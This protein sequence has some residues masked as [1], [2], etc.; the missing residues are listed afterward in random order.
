[1]T[2]V[3]PGPSRVVAACLLL[4]ALV[5]PRSFTAAGAGAAAAAA[6]RQGTLGPA[7]PASPVKLIFVH[8]ST[9]EAWLNDGYGGLG[10]ALRNNNYFV[11]DTNYGWGPDVIGDSTDIPHWYRW[12][13]GPS[14]EVYMAAVYA[15]SG[16]HSS[17]SRLASDP[18]G[19]NAIVMFKSCFPNS[20][21]GGNPNDPP[22]P[23]ANDSSLLTVANA[24]RIYLDLL[25]YFATHQEKLFVAIAA[26]PLRPEDT[27][28]ANAA[29]ARA[30]DNWLT[31]SWLSGY[32]YR[33]VSVFDYY[34]VL[35]S[36]GG[37]ASVN[38]LGAASGNH[39]RIRNGGVEHVTNQATDYL[40]YATGDS[41]PS[42]AGDL[43]ATGEFVGLL[44][45]FY[46]RWRSGSGTPPTFT[47]N[48]LAARGTVVKAVHVAEL[49]L[50]VADLRTRYGL[51]APSW[52]DATL[53]T[54][55]TPV[56]AIHVAELRAALG[57]V[58]SIAGRT[59]P[60]YSHASLT[61]Q[62][63]PVAAA[64]IAELRAAVVAMW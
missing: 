50:R 17:Y 14:R 30:F 57:D 13:T 49:R 42:Q 64:D 52:T 29:N 61:P 36:N 18:G 35:T 54:G 21:L 41:H 38:D 33:N 12:F 26:P 37:S 46:Q 19:P 45:L 56:K 28:A 24:K 62:Q 43:K 31:S 44:N 8:H 23:S 25:P 1:M 34:T 16:Q 4:L 32:A 6:R 58:Y 59:A 3:T 63:A 7:P 55:A 11:S 60:T 10:L 5:S 47:D 53:G 40:A 48:P 27:T 39:H 15:E 51:S 20:N 9:G 2:R 22:A